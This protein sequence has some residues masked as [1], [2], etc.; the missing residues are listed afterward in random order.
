MRWYWWLLVG[1]I[2]LAVIS[3]ASDNDDN[4]ADFT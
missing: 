2:L 1:Y 3:P 4:P